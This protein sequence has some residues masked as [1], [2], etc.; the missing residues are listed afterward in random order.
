M[1]IRGVAQHLIHDHLNFAFVRFLDETSKLLHRSK[2][3]VDLQ[4][5]GNVVAEVEHRRFDE[6]RDPDG[7]DA[8]PCEVVEALTNAVEIADPIASRVEEAARV[9][10]VDH[11]TLPPLQRLGAC[12]CRVGDL[13]ARGQL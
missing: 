11:R 9:D 7:I 8:K 12:S 1:L 10:V 5:V 3:G 13:L 2:Q 4:I 6:W